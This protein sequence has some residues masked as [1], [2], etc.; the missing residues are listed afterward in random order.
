MMADT[1]AEL[2][3]RHFKLEEQHLNITG[4][5]IVKALRKPAHRNV[6]LLMDVDQQNIP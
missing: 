1:W 5:D 3:N 6:S 4:D 2:I